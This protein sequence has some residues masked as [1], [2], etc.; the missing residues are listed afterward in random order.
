MPKA[1]TKPLGISQVRLYVAGNN[2]LTRARYDYYDPEA[3]SG[4]TAGWGTPP[5]KTITF[6][7]NVNF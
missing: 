3:V 2:L 4:G 7:L 6:G 1:W 5:L